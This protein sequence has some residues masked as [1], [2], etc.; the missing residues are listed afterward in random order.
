MESVFPKPLREGVSSWLR[1]NLL[2]LV[3]MMVLRLFFIAEVHIRLGIEASHFWGILGGSLF[4]L[5]LLCR[6]IAFFALP[7]LLFYYF[8]PKTTQRVYFGLIILYGIVSA[9]LTEYYCNL[10]MPL[11]HVV[12]VYTPE[13]VKGAASSSAS[14]TATPFL[15]FFS[16]M[17]VLVALN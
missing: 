13:E 3:F 16:T 1:Q 4:D 12:L 8:F 17:A 7:Y 2:L 15:W 9:L 6:M 14:V 5:T 11:D 10:S